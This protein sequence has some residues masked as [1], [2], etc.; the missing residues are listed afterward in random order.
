MKV[1][2]FGS[3]MSNLTAANL[4]AYFGYQQ[5]H[6]VA[7]NRSD[8]F[9]KTFVDRTHQNIP[10][11]WVES[12]L[13]YDPENEANTREA[14]RFLRNQHAEHIGFHD[15][16]AKQRPGKTFFDD[17]EEYE[18]DVILMDN[19][20]DVAAKLVSFRDA[21]QFEGRN[22]FIVPHF[23]R[24]QARLESLIDY[25]PFLTPA[26]SAANQ[27][28]IYRWLR[29]RQP[30]AKFFFLPF[31]SCTSLNAP[32]RYLRI[33]GFYEQFS[34]LAADE[35]IHI[36]RPLDLPPEETEGEG[37][38]PHFKPKVYTAMAGY[39]H[40]HNL[41]PLPRP[42]MPYVLPE[43]VHADQNRLQELV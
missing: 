1:M 27:L 20:M 36:M 28:R 18:I 43:P 17:L 6:N 14:K 4:D 22:L 29:E 37:D 21:P 7:H 33:R 8:H 31:H 9:L 24:N 15:H 38:W 25:T 12:V 34:A 30:R 3:C 11:E 26:E 13:E 35:D 42:G 32:G 2:A 23:Y 40:L 16:E 19:F 5:T 10:L 39:I 41:A